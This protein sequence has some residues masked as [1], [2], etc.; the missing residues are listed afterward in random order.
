MKYVQFSEL[1]EMASVN[2]SIA[3]WYIPWANDFR[4][5]RTAL[6]VSRSGI[7]GRDRVWVV[8]VAHS[9]GYLRQS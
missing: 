2:D 9:K 1:P 5:S 6:S 7:L 3:S 8:E 4:P